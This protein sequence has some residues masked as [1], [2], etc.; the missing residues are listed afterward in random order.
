M[1]R[2]GRS[3]SYVHCQRHWWLKFIFIM[4]TKFGSIIVAGSGKIGGHVASRNRA[5]SYLRTKVT[6]VNPSTVAQQGIRN[7]LTGLSQAWK[8][9]TAAQRLAWNAAVS[10]FAKT[11]VF[12][13]IRNPSGFNLFQRLNNNLL[14]CSESQID[15]PP[16]P[17]SVYAMATMSLVVVTGTPAL[18][19]TFTGAIPATAKVKLFATAPVSQ[20][21][22]FVKSEFRL[23]GVLSESDTSAKVITSLYTAKFGAVTENGL[24]V[25]VKAVPVNIATGQEGIGLIASAISVTS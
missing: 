18:T 19:L 16:V 5:G 15:V 7:R 9:L 25:F 11:D 1:G 8:A 3:S 10:D 2:V 4:K 6:P 12:G 14:I 20:G 22:S 21:V 17:G 23:I 24:K 13:D